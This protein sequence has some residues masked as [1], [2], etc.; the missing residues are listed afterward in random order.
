LPI[1]VVELIIDDLDNFDQVKVM[2]AGLHITSDIGNNTQ[3]ERSS[4]SKV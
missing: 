1:V 3:S 2:F 4:R